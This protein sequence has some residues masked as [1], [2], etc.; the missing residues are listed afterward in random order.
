M[1][2]RVTP[3]QAERIKKM[4]LLVEPKPVILRR[5]P[6][7]SDIL[8]ACAKPGLC[9][10][11]LVSSIRVKFPDVTGREVM[12]IVRALVTHGKIRETAHHRWIATSGWSKA[13]MT[14]INA[15]PMYP[16]FIG[17]NVLEEKTGIP[18]GSISPI[19]SKLFRLGIATPMQNRRGGI[20][21]RWVSDPM[22][23]KALRGEWKPLIKPFFRP[24][25]R[26]RAPRI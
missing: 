4:G 1:K 26:K 15:L 22:I 23:K 11:S 3:E 18:R 17:I 8:T 19:L 7:V 25:R 24:K 14:I 20:W 2:V 10:T 13:E 21:A 6:K 5:R 9:T 12:N 16:T